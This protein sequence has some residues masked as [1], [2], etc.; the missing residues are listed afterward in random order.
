MVRNA[1]NRRFRLVARGRRRER[2]HRR[3][4]SVLPARRDLFPVRRLCLDRAGHGPQRA[5]PALRLQA[6]ARAACPPAD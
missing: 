6:R 2:A 4:P 1:L 3:G 5:H